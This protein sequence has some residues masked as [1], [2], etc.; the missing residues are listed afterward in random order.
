MN[1]VC[2]WVVGSFLEPVL[3]RWRFTALALLS[4]LGGGVLI[5]GW[6][7][8]TGIPAAWNEITYDVGEW[9]VPTIGASGMV[10]GLFG[11]TVWV[12]RR[13]GG[14]LNGILGVLA[15][16]IVYTVARSSEV[17][18][19][20]HIGGLIVGLALGAVFAFV[21]RDRYL[22]YS[23]VATVVAT[24]ALIGVY[25]AFCTGIPNGAAEVWGQLAAY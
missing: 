19:Q 22:T 24:A 6:A 18:W 25:V 8:F 9:W 4:G 14:N 17:S 10:F 3:G 2:L 15:L 12:T 13:L 23:V 20:G 16:N 7:R 21:A 11:A 5:L 1:L